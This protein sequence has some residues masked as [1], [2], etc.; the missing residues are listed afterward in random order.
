[1][2]KPKVTHV[3]MKD[4]KGRVIYKRTPKSITMKGAAAQAFMK[5]FDEE[6]K[7]RNG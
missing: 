4:A 2:S 3:T 7:K 1:M 5:Q 6:E